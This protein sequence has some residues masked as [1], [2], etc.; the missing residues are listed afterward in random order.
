M[1]EFLICLFFTLKGIFLKG[2]FTYLKQVCV[3]FWVFVQK[4]DF[5]GEMIVFQQ[6]EYFYH[7]FRLSK[8]EKISEYL[9]IRTR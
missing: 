2:I 3:M 6:R 4:Q 5:S 7:F 8:Y 9:T 1:N